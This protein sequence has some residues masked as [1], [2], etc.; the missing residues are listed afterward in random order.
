MYGPIRDVFIHELGYPPPDVDIDTTGEGGRPDVTVRVPTGPFDE[1]GRGREQTVW[2][3]VEA[4][5]ERGCFR[6]EASRERIFERKAKY[7]GPDTAWF[8]MAEPELWVLRPCD[9][10]RAA[11]AGDIVIPLA[12][13]PSEL[14]ERWA[15]LSAARSGLLPQMDRFRDGDRALIA[16]V[17]LS[18][19]DGAPVAPGRLDLNRKHFFQ[20]IRAATSVLQD[21]VQLSLDRIQPQMDEYGRLAAEFWTEFPKEGVGFDPHTLSVRGRCQGAEDIRRRDRRVS[22][23]RQMF[24]KHP[25][26]ARVA[27]HGV[28]TFQARTGASDEN[29]R[30]LFAVETANLILARVLLLRFLEDHGFFGERRYVC[31][32]GVAAFQ[33]VRN[34]FRKSYADLLRDAFEEGS[35]LYAAAFDETELD[36]TFGLRDEALSRA[37]EWTLFR[38][39]RYDFTT[40]K[41][42]ILSGIYDRFMD[43]DKR[44]K[45]GEFY[46]PPSIARYIVQRLG[47]GRESVV[48]DPACGSGTFLIEAYRQMVGEDVDRG[49]AEYADVTSALQRI[50]GNDLNTFSAVLTQIQLLWQVLGFKREIELAGLFP[51]IPVTANVNSLLLRDL[52]AAAERFAELDVREYDAVI[53]NPPYVR[54][55]RSDQKLDVHTLEYFQG[56]GVSGKLNAYALFLFRALDRWCKAAG[57][58]GHAGK[59]GFVMPVSLFDSNDTA[60]LRRLFSVGGRW[61]IREI[62][63]LEA[64]HRD[65][66]DADVYPAILVAEN[67]PAQAADEVSVRI[68]DPSC[69]RR[70]GAEAVA[71]FALGA[72]PESRIAYPDLFSPDGRILTRL[73]ERRVA[74][75][76]KIRANGVL[77]DACKRIWVRRRRGR[78]VEWTDVP[79]ARASRLRWEE[80]PLCAGGLA[81]RRHKPQ[82]PGGPDVFKGENIV[83]TELQGEPVLTTVD[84]RGVDDPGPWRYLNLLPEHGY[85]VAQV[86]HCPNAVPFDPRRV[87]FTNTATVFFPRQDLLGVPF[88]LLLLS[89]VYVWFYAIGTRMGVVRMACSHIYPTNLALSPWSEDLAARAAAIEGLRADVVAASRNAVA[90]REALEEDL[91]RLDLQTLK[92]RAQSVQARLLWSDAFDRP[93]CQA[94]IGAVETVE[95]DDGVAVRLSGNTDDEIIC[96]DPAI[97]RGLALALA[98]YAGQSFTRSDLLNLRIP[99]SDGER[100]AWQAVVDRHRRETVEQGMQQALARLDALVGEALGLTADDIAEIQRDLR[101]DPFLQKIRPRYPGTVTRKQGFRAGLD[102]KGRYG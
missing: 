40:I 83:A 100:Q 18:S 11:A 51:D 47:V 73:T 38:F 78:I 57:A 82:T 49:T 95:T 58:D 99:C 55:E 4:K 69:V 53:G 102:S 7:I 32:G 33:N 20:E 86:T 39:A 68:A 56:R 59:V 31:N 46:T 97:A 12:L 23:L 88:D 75:L 72:L 41:G 98:Q 64:I 93:D 65:V 42:D 3:V 62:V 63:D 44:K 43:R 13:R 54:V 91:Q 24:S 15:P 77:L 94:S 87:A 81:F 76:R 36:W 84:L 6:D 16:T 74:V 45:F 67:C 96:S 61:A 101:E 10:G 2:I 92:T 1:H 89:N 28:S 22:H 37:I 27:L 66:F 17:P 90:V 70:T 50:R 29:V 35:R 26:I 71:D 14:S 80:K 9:G 25:S 85:A 48:L 60:D 52:F 30:E 19:P 8:V 34:Y 79:P 5:D 21:I